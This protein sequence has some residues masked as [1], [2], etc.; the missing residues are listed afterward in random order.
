MYLQE[1]TEQTTLSLTIAEVIQTMKTGKGTSE[2]Q[3]FFEI[4]P[5]SRNLVRQSAFTFKS[6]N[7]KSNTFKG[8]YSSQTAKKVKIIL[9]TFFI[10]LQI[11]IQDILFLHQGP[12][13]IRV[14]NR[15]YCC[16]FCVDN[17]EFL[18]NTCIFSAEY[19]FKCL[20]TYLLYLL[21]S[22]TKCF[23]VVKDLS[24]LYEISAVS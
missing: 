15:Q 10:G 24:F 21:Y 8:K 20:F 11:N 7:F 22:T 5:K 6:K 18:H 3:L 12:Q 17:H 2:C 23:N 13:N 14:H 19:T 1:Q 4:L 16:Q 9:D